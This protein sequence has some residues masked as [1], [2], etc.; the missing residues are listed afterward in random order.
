MHNETL[1]TVFD[2]FWELASKHKNFAIALLE[3]VGEG[4]WQEKALY[5]YDDLET[6][7][8]YEL[9]EGLYANIFRDVTLDELLDPFDYIDFQAFGEDISKIWN[10][11]RFW[12]DGTYVVETD[13]GW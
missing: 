11:S 7:A 6:F 1:Y 2:N 10:E 5:L 3:E 13:Y 8:V 4:D 12:T 9:Y